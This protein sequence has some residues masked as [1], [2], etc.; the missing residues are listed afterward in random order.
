MKKKQIWSLTNVSGHSCPAF[1]RCSQVLSSRVELQGS[2]CLCLLGGPA[3]DTLLHICSFF[4][5]QLIGTL[6][7]EDHWLFSDNDIQWLPD[8]AGDW[9]R[10][11]LWFWRHHPTHPN[12]APCRSMKISPRQMLVVMLLQTLSATNCSK[13]IFL[14]QWEGEYMLDKQIYL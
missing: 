8:G 3:G 10:Q 14:C 2:K 1:L 11:I 7:R 6:V 5:R 12:S 4:L 13:L 9:S